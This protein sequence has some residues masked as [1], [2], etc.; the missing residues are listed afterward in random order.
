MKIWDVLG[1]PPTDNTREI[2]RAYAVALKRTHPEDDPEGFRRLREAYELALRI[3]ENQATL[4]DT[5]ELPENAADDR[6]VVETAAVEA[7]QRQRPDARQRAADLVQEIFAA[8]QANGEGAATKALDKILAGEELANLGLRDHFEEALVARLAAEENL[9]AD[10]I[11]HAAKRFSW[12]EAPRHLLERL[13]WQIGRLLSRLRARKVRS[14]LALVSKE[15]PRYLAAQ[16]LFGRFRPT[17]YRFALLFRRNVASMRL[18]LEE[19]QAKAPELFDYE[20][21]R[22]IVDWWELRVN[23]PRI[24]LYHVAG[25]YAL[26]L[27]FFQLQDVWPETQPWRA[28]AFCTLIGLMLA[29]FYGWEA[30]QLRAPV[31]RMAMRQKRWVRG[32][33]VP[34]SAVLI[35]IA[36]MSARWPGAAVAA[37]SLLAVIA[38]L[39]AILLFYRT[40]LTGLFSLAVLACLYWIPVQLALQIHPGLGYLVAILLVLLVLGGEDGVLSLAWNAPNPD[41]HERAL[42]RGWIAVLAALALVSVFSARFPPV[43]IEGLAGLWVLA[44]AWAAIGTRYW[45]FDVHWLVKVGPPAAFATFAVLLALAFRPELP[46]QWQLDPRLAGLL[47]T[48]LGAGPVLVAIYLRSRTPSRAE[49]A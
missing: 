14:N 40:D 43:V 19:L 29:V 48:C 38:S 28:V 3:A 34:V 13:P 17:S 31:L 23:R 5:D 37:L 46:P 49:A 2:R 26:P 8:L 6:R 47:G 45:H 18:L 20:I 11:A 39:W 36:A 4:D 10:L 16:I 42:R 30:L 22:R 1:V 15:D 41:R 44:L 21:D 25:L 32:G 35:A 33:W 24:Y 9:P 12:E 7:R 27:V